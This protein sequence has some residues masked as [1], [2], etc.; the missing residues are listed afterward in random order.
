MSNNP[1]LKLIK[2]QNSL[3]FSRPYGRLLE[4]P[5]TC[6]SWE[7]FLSENDFKTCSRVNSRKWLKK[8]NLWFLELYSYLKYISNKDDI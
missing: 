2:I 3:D 5:K 6:G 7:L 8:G 1:K 4:N